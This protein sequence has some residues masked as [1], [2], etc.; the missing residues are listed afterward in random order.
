[1]YVR[2]ELRKKE[3]STEVGTEKSGDN[4]D[5]YHGM[6]PWL[7]R[8]VTPSLPCPCPAPWLEWLERPEAAGRVP[9]W[10]VGDEEDCGFRVPLGSC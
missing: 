9:W 6:F 1:M 3:L 10:T 4:L 2:A 5:D 8:V 7:E